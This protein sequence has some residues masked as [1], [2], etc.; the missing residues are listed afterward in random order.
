[1]DGTYEISG[2]PPGSYTL[3]VF[4]Q[5]SEG[6]AAA[7][8]QVEIGGGNTVDVTLTLQPLPDVPCSVSVEGAGAETIQQV[9]VQLV[10][11]DGIPTMRPPRA[12]TKPGEP[13]VLKDVLPGVWDINVSPLP[14]GGYIKA[15]YLGERDVLRQDMQISSSTSDTLRV[16]I[17]ARG[18]SL[19]GKVADGKP[20]TILLA[21]EGESSRVLSFYRTAI[22]DAA[23]YWRVEGA[24]P[25][26]YRVYAFEEVDAN[27]WQNPEFLQPFQPYSA[28]VELSE[29]D[30]G[31]A[32]VTLIPAGVAQ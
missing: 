6:T 26:T 16:V 13:C 10:R 32:E 3:V 27:A 15:M 28:I 22:S 11:G 2:I 8:Q 9:T 7:L 4:H 25:G 21:P 20:A 12:S 14:K 18:A 1:V 23:G 29:G 19:G 31:K 24:R 5:G 17:A 30:N